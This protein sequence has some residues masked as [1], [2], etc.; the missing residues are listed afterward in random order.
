MGSF[1]ED[2]LADKVFRFVLGACLG[3]SSAWYLAARRGTT[4]TREFVTLA[5][6]GAGAV[7]LLAVLLG[8]RFIETFI[9]RRWWN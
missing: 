9:R 7:G 2:R 4:E 5:V 1:A 6:I 8:N 3:A